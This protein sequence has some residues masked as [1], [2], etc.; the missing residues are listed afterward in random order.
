LSADSTA[1]LAADGERAGSRIVRRLVEDWVSGANRFHRPG[2]VLLGAWLDGRL[3]GVCG[4][5]VDPY[6]AQDR[7]GRV[8]HLYVLSAVRRLGV[9]RRLTTEVIELARGRF[10]TLRLRTNNPDAARLY[11]A[12]GFRATADVA[13]ATHVMELASEHSLPALDRLRRTPGE[14]ERMIAG[15]TDAELSRRPDAKNWAAKEIVCH[16]RD[17]EELFQIRFHTVVALDEPRIL[18]L[19][20]SPT[21]LA[22]WRIG[23]AIGHPL[24]PGRW[25]EERQYLRNDTREALAAF[26]RRRAEVLT[27]L[28]SLTPAEWRRGGIHLGRG[29]LT[30]ADWVDSLVGHDANHV[31]QLRRA[32]D[33][34]P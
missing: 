3:V 5:N 20:A 27:L 21:D 26:R 2:E 11:E 10:D 4:L 9:G 12:L 22:A 32:L 19:G 17:V 28:E 13:G 33:G 8:R 31:D 30:L 15:K 23:G 16:L 25:A 34:R 6:A 24:D 1:G 18:V 14:L 29:R 7:V